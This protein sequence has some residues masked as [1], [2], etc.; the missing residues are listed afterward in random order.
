MPLATL[1]Q[2]SGQQQRRPASAARQEL[3]ELRIY[4]DPLAQ[5]PSYTRK[6]GPRIE[7]QSMPFTSSSPRRR[8]RRRPARFIYSAAVWY[9]PARP[10]SSLV[11][12]HRRPLWTCDAAPP[13][14]AH[15]CAGSMAKENR[16]VPVNRKITIFCYLGVTWTL[17]IGVLSTGGGS[18][19][20]LTPTCESYSN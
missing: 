15:L 18:S 17:G 13:I 4:S 6:S 8:R 20:S 7:G 12:S 2:A 11:G 10:C 14:L 5:N 1:R 3:S 9:T 16:R 19:D